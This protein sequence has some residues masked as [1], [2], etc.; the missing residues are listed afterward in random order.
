MGREL[1]RRVCRTMWSNCTPTNCTAQEGVTQ[2][3]KG[4]HVLVV[5]AIAVTSRRKLVEMRFIPHRL[6][7]G[8]HFAGVAGM[9]AVV[10]KARCD[11]DRWIG[12]SWSRRVIGGNSGEKLPVLGLAGIAV[13]ISNRGADQKL[14]ISTHVDD[15]H[16]AEQCAKPLRI[17]GEHIGYEQAAV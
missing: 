3:Y 9:G 6:Q 12:V 14:G 4:R 16:R 15:G 8:G 11:Q 13:F 2:R 1:T 5:L 17:A 10:A 7:L